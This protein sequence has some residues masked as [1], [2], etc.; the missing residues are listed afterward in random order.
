L[1]P[2][3]PVNAQPTTPEKETGIVT[4][5]IVYDNYAHTPGL[6]TDWGFA[7][8][9]E[10]RE[11][12][13]L[14]DTGGNGAILM[15]NLA[16]I[17]RDPLAIDAVVLSHIHGDHTGGLNAL[18]DTGATPTVYVPA[19]FPRSFKN[20][21]R[22]HT[23]LIEISQPG[24][25]LP[26]IHTTGQL[27][28][29]IVEQALAVETQE[30]LVVITGCAHP[31]IVTMVQQARETV[32][33]PIALVMGGF[34]LGGADQAQIETIIAQFKE[35]GARQV[36]PCHCTG[37]RAIEMFSEAFGKNLIRVGAGAQIVIGS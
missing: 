8:L 2:T 23:A 34:H 28:S 33:A 17:D 18:L 19:S 10:T 24:E 20:Q 3:P 26:S 12:T 35:L 37:D 11:T 15:G 25:I 5:T 16:K 9:V 30:G 13:L 27:G 6:E 31:G 4:L 22:A 7:C 21:V 29:S 32:N 1:A 36:A 14:F